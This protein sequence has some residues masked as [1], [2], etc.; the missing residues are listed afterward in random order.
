MKY[1]IMMFGDA[2]TAMETKSREWLVEMTTFMRGLNQELAD[3]GEL[4]V[5]EGLADSVRAKTVT[6]VDGAPVVTDGPFAEA[7]E[8]LIGFWIVDV[9]DEARVLAIGGRIVAY[10]ERLEIRPVLGGPPEL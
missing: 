6:L 8:S 4:V 5:A 7:K 2:A 3:N 1:M 9:E 10:S